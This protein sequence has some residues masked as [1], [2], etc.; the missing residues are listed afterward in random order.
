MEHEEKGSL[1]AYLKDLDPEAA[2]KITP[3]DTRRIIRALEVILKSNATMSGMQ[4]KYTLPLPYD[5]V[6]IGLTRE[7]KELYRMI[8]ERVE[9]RS[10]IW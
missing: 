8:E 10:L 6:K 3:N 1:Y 7:R 4:K 5:F 9:R 2:E